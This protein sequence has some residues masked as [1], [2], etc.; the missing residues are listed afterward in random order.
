MVHAMTSFFSR[1]KQYLAPSK[2]EKDK[3]LNLAPW[4][5][6]A[7]GFAIIL[8][9][10]YM[11]KPKPKEERRLEEKISTPVAEDP[12]ENKDKKVV[13]ENPKKSLQGTRERHQPGMARTHHI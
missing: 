12:Q 2:E 4:L 10:A 8:G 9:Q 5:A 13:P 6:A 7:A 11:E 3:D 1:M